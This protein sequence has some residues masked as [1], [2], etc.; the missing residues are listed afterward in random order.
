ML[1]LSFRLMLGGNVKSACAGGCY[2]ADGSFG[3]VL[4][5]AF[6]LI[7]A[8]P[9]D[10]RVITVTNLLG[11]VGAATWLQPIY[12]YSFLLSSIRSTLQ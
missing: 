7:F 3:Y 9:L 5:I 6:P 4:G 1:F 8:L 12:L 11:D 2:E 10:W